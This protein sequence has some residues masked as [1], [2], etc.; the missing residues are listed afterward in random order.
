MV[1]AIH[2]CKSAR[3]IHV[4][5]P[6]WTSLHPPAPVTSPTH[7]CRY[8]RSTG[9]FGCPTSF[10]KLALVINLL[11]VICMFQYCSIKSSH[12]PLLP[13]SPKLCSLCLCLLCCPAHRIIGTIFLVSI[14]MQITLSYYFI[15]Y[16][17]F[18][19]QLF[20]NPNLRKIQSDSCTIHL[21]HCFITLSSISFCVQLSQWL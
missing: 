12:L 17:W 7:P 6:S 13:L 5:P 2:Q 15:V 1:F 11:T 14:Y 20:K 16:Y 9:F 8:S 21:K 4:F 18:F 3:G 19:S 10:I